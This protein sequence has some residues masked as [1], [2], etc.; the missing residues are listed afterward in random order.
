[1]ES[2]RYEIIGGTE[3]GRDSHEGQGGENGWIKHLLCKHE[4]L[5]THISQQWPHMSLEAKQKQ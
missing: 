2:K 4:D 1:M 3:R 5:V